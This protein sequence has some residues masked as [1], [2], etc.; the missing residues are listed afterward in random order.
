MQQA[1]ARRFLSTTLCAAA[2]LAAGVQP[3]AAQT[4][5]VN[6]ASSA[7]TGIADANASPVVPVPPSELYGAL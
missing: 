5:S 6:P 2:L 4:L 7:A 1:H 3:A